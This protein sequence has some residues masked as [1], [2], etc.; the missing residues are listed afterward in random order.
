MRDKTYGYPSS[1]SNNGDC[2]MYLATIGQQL[3]EGGNFNVNHVL[4]GGDVCDDLK[5]TVG[6]IASKSRTAIFCMDSFEYRSIVE[7]IDST[8]GWNLMYLDINKDYALD[9]CMLW[10]NHRSGNYSCNERTSIKNDPKTDIHPGIWA[11]TV[12]NVRYG[13]AQAPNPFE[14]DT[15][16]RETLNCKESCEQNPYQNA[17]YEAVYTLGRAINYTLMNSTSPN[18]KEDVFNVDEL[19]KHFYGEFEMR[20]YSNRHH[21]T[22]NNFVREKR[23]FSID[24]DLDVSLSVHQFVNTHLNRSTSSSNWANS[25]RAECSRGIDNGET[26]HF[27]VCPVGQCLQRSRHQPAW[28]ECWHMNTTENIL[29]QTGPCRC[30]FS[31]MSSTKCNL[32]ISTNK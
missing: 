26:E 25:D 11:T 1:N 16:S 3:N 18:P 8:V 7:A 9:N 30:M 20:R 12:I 10:S 22:S 28:H 19:L 21:F 15:S 29:V 32:I 23:R 14:L 6:K 27:K 2:H 13:A 31:E 17:Y 4:V 24:H 5:G